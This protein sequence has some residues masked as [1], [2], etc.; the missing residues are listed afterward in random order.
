MSTQANDYTEKVYQDMVSTYE[1]MKAIVTKTES[2]WRTHGDKLQ[3]ACDG[4]YES[5]KDLAGSAK[6]CQNQQ[7]RTLS[8]L[9]RAR[10][11]SPAKLPIKGCADTKVDSDLVASSD[12]RCAGGSEKDGCKDPKVTSDHTLLC[13]HLRRAV[14]PKMSLQ[15]LMNEDGACNVDM[16][17]VFNHALLPPSVPYAIQ[18]QSL[19]SLGSSGLVLANPVVLQ[20]VHHAR[21]RRR[22]CP[23]AAAA[24]RCE[25][26]SSA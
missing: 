25:G 26:V 3:K 7:E 13:T 11:A 4:I 5:L 21:S 15:N 14:L 17:A 2:D 9:F 20:T 16:K 1:K 23:G 12:C 18:E 22:C 24:A 10:A 19:A 6:T 8:D